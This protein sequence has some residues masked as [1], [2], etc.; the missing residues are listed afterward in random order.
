MIKTLAAAALIAYAAPQPWPY[1]TKPPSVHTFTETGMLTDVILGNH[2]GGMTIRLPDGRTDHFFIAQ[3]NKVNGRHYYCQ[4]FPTVRE[5]VPDRDLCNERPPVVVGE[6]RVRVSWWWSFFEDHRAKI[7][8]EMWTVRNERYGALTSRR[9]DL[10]SVR[11]N[12]NA[13]NRSQR[14]TSSRTMRP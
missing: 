13:R 5:R 14:P 7:S 4:I 10:P 12:E 8:D 3:P 11:R 2:N 9:L 1:P 6:T